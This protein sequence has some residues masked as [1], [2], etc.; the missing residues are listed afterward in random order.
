MLWRVRKLLGLVKEPSREESTRLRIAALRSSGMVVGEQVGIVN[1][2]LDSLF[3]FLIEI[4]S[5]VLMTHATILA[6]DASPVVFGNRTRVGRV[7]V[8]DH[9]FVGVG[10]VILPGVTIGPRAIVGANAVVSR[11]VPPDSVVAGN[12]ARVVAQVD[13]WLQRKQDSG[14]LVTWAG[15]IVPTD[16]QVNAGRDAVRAHFG[17]D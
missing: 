4:G 17:I 10:A 7:R 12:P 5:N 16:Q 9:C 11:N 13:E 8:L 3:P 15:G 14:E 1:C 6:H 2:T